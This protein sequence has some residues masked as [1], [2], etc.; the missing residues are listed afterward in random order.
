MRSSV[1]IEGVCRFERR[2]RQT[3]KWPL[4]ARGA[5][6][7]GRSAPRNDEEEGR[8]DDDETDRS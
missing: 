2:K 8:D 1:T 4:M 6:G 3:P 5:A 7:K